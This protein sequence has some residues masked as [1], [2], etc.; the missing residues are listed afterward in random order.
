MSDLFDDERC[1]EEGNPDPDGK[2][3]LCGCGDLILFDVDQCENCR[4]VDELVSWSCRDRGP[5][6]AWCVLIAAHPGPHFGNGYD[7]MHQ[8]TV[9]VWW[10]RV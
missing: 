7:E 2:W 3:K 6:S 10:N 9:P 8:R 5:Q 4:F 1:D